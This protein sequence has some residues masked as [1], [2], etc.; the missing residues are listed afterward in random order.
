MYPFAHVRSDTNEWS[1]QVWPNLDCTVVTASASEWMTA[2]AR[3]VFARLGCEREINMLGAL[4]S[5]GT[6]K[7]FFA[8]DL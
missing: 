8:N 7:E 5:H 2:D 1:W 6:D 3:L 4:Q